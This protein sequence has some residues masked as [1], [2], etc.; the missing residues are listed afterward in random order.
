MFPNKNYVLGSG[1]IY[2][3]KYL[4]G[5]R[6]AEPQRYFGNTPAFSTNSESESLDHFDADNGTRTKDD[7][8]LLQLNRAGSLITDHISPPNLALWFLGQ[9][10]V[11]T[12]SAAASQTATLANAQKGRRYQL[13]VTTNNPSGLRGLT[14]TLITDDTSPTPVPLVAGVDYIF[15]GDTGGV[16]ILD[17]STIVDGTKDVIVTY[18]VVATTYNRV[19]SGSSAQIEGELLFKAV[20]AKGLNMDYYYPYVQL[21]PDGDYELKSEEWQQL[22]FTF[23]ALK[24]DD[25]TEVVYINGRPGQGI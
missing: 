20:N 1:K 5:T 24:R 12:Q 7:S 11:V 13:G 16:E 6:T 3:G 17:T 19:I 9:E 2:F 18:A 10:S 14:L 15:D 22:G 23:Q 8:A 25:N 4:E 21:Q